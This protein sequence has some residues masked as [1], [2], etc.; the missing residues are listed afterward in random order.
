M[1]RGKLSTFATTASRWG[2]RIIV[3]TAVKRG[4]PLFS[5]DVSQAFLRGM[6]FEDLANIPGEAVRKVQMR[7][8]PGSVALLRRFEGYEDFDPLCEV[9]ELLRPGFGLVDAP[10][11]WGL[12]FTHALKENAFVPTQVDTQLFNP[13]EKKE[14]W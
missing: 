11:L 12:E 1:Q 2:Q 14:R 10:R 13:F 9:L 3:S 8:P 7:L 5:A 4:W 6:T